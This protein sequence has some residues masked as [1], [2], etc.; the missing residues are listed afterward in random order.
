M[1]GV[2]SRGTRDTNGKLGIGLVEVL[3][4]VDSSAA[5]N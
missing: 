4:H 3:H 5:N 2:L 1:M